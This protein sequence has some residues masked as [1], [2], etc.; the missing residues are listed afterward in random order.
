VL[1]FWRLK[2][3]VDVEVGGGLGAGVEVSL[4]VHVRWLLV[5]GRK[6]LLLLLL[7]LSLG[8]VAR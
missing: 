2:G 5:F 6:L 7:L 3:R 4:P 1:L 8:Q